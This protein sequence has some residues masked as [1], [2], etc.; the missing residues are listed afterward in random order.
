MIQIKNEALPKNT[1][2][3]QCMYQ[4]KRRRY[5]ML[6]KIVKYGNSSALV[7]DKALL[8]LLN[9]EE[10]SVVKIKT[11]GISLIITPQYALAQQTI[12]TTLTMEETLKDATKTALAQ[13]FGDPEKAHAYQAAL[14]EVSDRYATIIKNKMASP[15]I[16][17][18]IETVQK[19]FS[20]D[21]TNP[22]YAKELK[23]IQQKYIPELEQMNQEMDALIKKYAIT[24]SREANISLLREE[25]TKVHAKYGH[26]LQAVAK[27]SEDPEFI[28]EMMLL[29]E[30]YQIHKDP[31]EYSEAYI[32]LVSKKIPEYTA[33]Q[34]ELKKAGNQPDREAKETKVPAQGSRRKKQ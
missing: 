15:E 25:F 2:Y 18:T 26:V 3:I 19:R 16:R 17:Q 34:E 4:V 6:K 33:Y 7:L 14:K 5:A 24:N 12:S 21:Q 11:D 13:S 1:K 31:K 20:N 23:K 30:K 22:E 27:L 28:H 10:G 29:S 32:Q 9:M 8:E